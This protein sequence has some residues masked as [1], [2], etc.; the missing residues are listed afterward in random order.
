MTESKR[1]NLIDFLRFIAA[2][3]VVLYHIYYHPTSRPDNFYANFFFKYGKLGVPMF[4]VISGY[5]VMIAL[6]HTKNPIEFIIRRLFRIFPP[7]WFSLIF[8][9]FIIVLLRLLYGYN[10]VAILPKTGRDIFFTICML[11]YPFTKIA[12]INWS[13]WTL[14]YEVLFYITV[15]LSS[16]FKKQYFMFLLILITIG[17]YVVP[18]TDLGFLSFFK[19]WPLFCLGIALFKILNDSKSQLILNVFLLCLALF[20]FYPAHQS[21]HF[22]IASILTAILIAIAHYKPLPNNSISRLGDISYS[23]Y[24]IHI[25]LTVYCFDQF[26]GLAPFRFNSLLNFF[27]DILLLFGL[28]CISK[29]TYKY[30]ELPSINIGKS[31][32]R[33]PLSSQF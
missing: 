29:L 16:C 30:I 17:S 31:Y 24:L 5:C 7:Y 12:P 19:F 33:W 9:L 8:T 1:N 32:R 2:I 22:F 10:S 18:S 14:L 15:F 23:I 28:I 20:A 21:V 13:Y 3:S 6:R 11:T 26:R 4:F 25:P 27:L